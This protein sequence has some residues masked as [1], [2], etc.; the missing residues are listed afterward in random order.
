MSILDTG[1]VRLKPMKGMCLHFSL[2]K[3]GEVLE[4]DMA[5]IQTYIE[6]YDGKVS[7][8]VTRDNDE[9]SMSAGAQKM[10]FIGAGSRVKAVAFIDRSDVDTVLSTYADN[11]YLSHVDVRSFHDA[12]KAFEWISCYGPLPP[13]K[14]NT[15]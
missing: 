8:F 13:L 7:L 5:L 9:Y 6:Q 15:L 10:M 11:S 4:E 2:Y 14:A 1:R 3:N 12:E